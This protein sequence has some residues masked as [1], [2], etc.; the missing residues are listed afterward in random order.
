MGF[1]LEQLQ[2]VAMTDVTP[3]P[4]SSTAMEVTTTPTSL[5]SASLPANIGG[6]AGGGSQLS[7]LTR[8]TEE[9]GRVKPPP[10]YPTSPP[11]KNNSSA[12][13]VGFI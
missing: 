9:G 7:K 6:A 13:Q 11:Q 3:I 2:T 4:T 10:P 1:D 12:L 8:R 5:L